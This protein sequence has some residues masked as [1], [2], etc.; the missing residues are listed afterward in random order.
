MLIPRPPVCRTMVSVSCKQNTRGPSGGCLWAWHG[1]R[2]AWLCPVAE[3]PRAAGH[4]PD[5]G[6]GPCPHLQMPP[7]SPADP[8]TP[9]HPDKTG[10]LPRPQRHVHP[11]I[12]IRGHPGPTRGG[13]Q[14]HGRACGAG[15]RRRESPQPRTRSTSRERVQTSSSSMR[16]GSIS[17]LLAGSNDTPCRTGPACSEPR[18]PPLQPAPRERQ[19]QEAPHETA[20]T[21]ASPSPPA[22]KCGRHHQ[23]GQSPRGG[24]PCSGQRPCL[25]V[26]LAATASHPCSGCK[27]DARCTEESG[28]H[29]PREQPGTGLA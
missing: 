12:R 18:P 16:A 21:A 28:H 19:G 27:L 17:R 25:T 9:W 4:R 1:A 20:T 26:P 2:R 11:S 15:V 14:Q 8:E 29:V 6:R 3:E 23:R 10:C 22:P 7:R 5:G 13:G 24:G